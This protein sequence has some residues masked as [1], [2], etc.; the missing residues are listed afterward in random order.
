MLPGRHRSGS[1]D[2]CPVLAHVRDSRHGPHSPLAHASFDS[3]VPTA[4][5]RVP[6]PGCEARL[7]AV[8]CGHLTKAG[9]VQRAGL[10][11]RLA[12]RGICV[13]R[14]A[15][16]RVPRGAA[17]DA[18][19]HRVPLALVGKPIVAM[20]VLVRVARDRLGPDALIAK[21]RTRP[22]GVRGAWPSEGAMQATRRDGW[23]CGACAAVLPLRWPMLHPCH[24]L[25]PPLRLHPR[26]DVG[27]RARAGSCSR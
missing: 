26:A 23:A 10:G 5:G 6:Y 21:A 13:H 24:R 17:A 11:M 22:H 18:R 8:S 19:G 20:A 1:P 16:G 25:P 4:P 3:R 27:H 12:H 15:A 2:W 14:R 9:R 7:A